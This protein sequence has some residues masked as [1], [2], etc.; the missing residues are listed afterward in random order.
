MQDGY[1]C[2]P[3]GALKNAGRVPMGPVV[4]ESGFDDHDAEYWARQ[5]RVGA[6]IAAGITLLG[7]LRVLLD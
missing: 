2:R 3:A 4:L 6:L 1:I 7:G 5:V